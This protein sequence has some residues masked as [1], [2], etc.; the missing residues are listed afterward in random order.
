MSDLMIVVHELVESL[1]CS[2]GVTVHSLGGMYWTTKKKRN[3]MYGEGREAGRH[4]DENS[5]VINI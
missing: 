3:L 2:F 1:W 5:L 4:N